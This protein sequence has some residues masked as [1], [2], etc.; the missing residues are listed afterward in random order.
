MSGVSVRTLHF[1]DETGLLKPARHGAN[2]YRFYEEP[3]LLTL[4]QILFYRELG[5]ELKQIEQILGRA[6]FEK[7][8]ALQSHRKVLEKNLARTRTLIETIDKTIE[9][10]KGTKK[11]KTE[12][13]FMGFSVAAGKDRF[14]ETI[15]VGGE[16]NDCKVSAQ[17]THGAMCVFELTGGIWSGPRHFHH[18]QD[19]WIYILAGDFHF[20]VGD[21]KFR[22]GPGESVFLP[23]KVPHG[24]ACVSGNPGKVIDVYQPAG[25]MEEF[26]REAGKYK[27]EPYAHEA[28]TF[29]EFRQLFRDHGMDLAGPPLFGE[30][31]VEGGR[32]VQIA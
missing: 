19:E 29:D 15:R 26:F 17:D 25:K 4:Q 14:G 2:G 7:V 21:R 6:D 1:Y 28:L 27:G 11:M 10:L 5:F 16:P 9:H 12:E 18:D 24:W 31:K 30:W 23:R 20:E 8:A 32:I 13:M 3:Q 22:A